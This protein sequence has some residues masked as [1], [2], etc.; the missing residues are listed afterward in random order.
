MFRLI[1]LYVSRVSR[2]EVCLPSF[3]VVNCELSVEVVDKL[4]W[5]KYI[6]RF[7]SCHFGLG[8]SRGLAAIS[9]LAWF[10]IKTLLNQVS[11]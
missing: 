10:R 2:E 7:P 11:I 8:G 1:Y 9:S 5:G 3:D 4:L 6:Y